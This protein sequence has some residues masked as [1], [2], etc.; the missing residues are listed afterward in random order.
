[1]CISKL[2]IDKNTN[3]SLSKKDHPQRHLPTSPRRPRPKQRRNR[4]ERSTEGGFTTLGATFLF[5]VTIIGIGSLVI[6]NQIKNRTQNQI[7]LDQLTGKI[8]IQLRASLITI[9]ESRNRLKIAKAAMLGG[10]TA[11]IASCP[12]LKRAYDLEV[13]VEKTIQKIAEEHWEVQKVYW[14]TRSPVMSIRSKLPKI[15]EVI[16]N[17]ELVIKIQSSGLISASKTWKTERL[18]SNEWKIAWVE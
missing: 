13:K 2:Q 8:A 12:A 9:E 6:L 17:Q 4:N 10:C 11:V 1:M 5:L 16:T 14:L 15:D 3:D 7:E 18:S